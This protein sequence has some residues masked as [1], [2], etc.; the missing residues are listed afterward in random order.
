MTIGVTHDLKVKFLLAVINFFSEAG[1]CV[2]EV[3]IAFVITA[4]NAVGFRLSGVIGE[5]LLSDF[6]VY[7]AVNKTWTRIE[8]SNVSKYLLAISKTSS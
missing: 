5:Q 8:D 2:D 7:G 4:M 1:Y 6:C 3:E